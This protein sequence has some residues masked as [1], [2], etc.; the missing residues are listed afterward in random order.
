MISK[1]IVVIWAL[2]ALVLLAVFY[3]DN[4][5]VK[6]FS[7]MRSPL[8]NQIFLKINFISQGAIIFV[9]ITLPFLLKK[10]R[11]WVLPLW[12]SFAISIATGF[13]IKIAVQRPRPFQTGIISSLIENT[14]GKWDFSFPSHHAIYIFCALPL[15]SKEFPKL[16]Y[17]WIILAGL[18][19]FSRVYL[20]VHFLSDVI[21]GGVIGYMLGAFVLKTEKENKFFEKIYR[22]VFRK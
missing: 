2:V 21:S 15:L 8:L 22:K 13:L 12:F 19:A 5:I 14:V 17:L 16:K 4:E 10:H 20:G 11:K 18:V 6:I 3:F 9:L 1:K 7:L